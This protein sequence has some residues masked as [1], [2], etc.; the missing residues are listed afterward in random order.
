[1]QFTRRPYAPTWRQETSE[2]KQFTR[3]RYKTGTIQYY[4]TKTNYD[5]V[6]SLR[7]LC[8]FQKKRKPK[9]PPTVEPPQ[10]ATSLQ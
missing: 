5:G 7:A 9:D 1:M 2:V 3:R 10:S 6:H 4:E 8:D